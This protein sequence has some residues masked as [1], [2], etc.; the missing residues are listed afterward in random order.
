MTQDEGFAFR[1]PG[2]QVVVTNDVSD[3]GRKQGLTFSRILMHPD[4]RPMM[5][6]HHTNTDTPPYLLF[7]A[8]A[9]G[10]LALK[11]RRTAH[12]GCWS[13]GE[14]FHPKEENA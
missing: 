14:G 3:Q 10:A 2:I 6:L 9:A 7:G 5:M 8:L 11:S 4:G 1:L 13:E 12:A